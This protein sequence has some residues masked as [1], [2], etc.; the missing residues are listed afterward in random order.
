MLVY[1]N[2]LT[3]SRYSYIYIYIY[4]QGDHFSGKVRG[5]FKLW[6]SLKTG[7]VWES[8]IMIIVPYCQHSSQIQ[9]LPSKVL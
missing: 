8:Q 2:L 3:K 4:I 9:I 5:F 1:H 7:K 6:K